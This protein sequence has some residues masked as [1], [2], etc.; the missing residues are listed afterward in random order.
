LWGWTV[1]CMYTHSGSRTV[2][3]G[4]LFAHMQ[5]NLF[6]GAFVFIMVLC[7]VYRAPEV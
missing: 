6:L 1:K 5:F 3:G 2:S 4:C 7:L